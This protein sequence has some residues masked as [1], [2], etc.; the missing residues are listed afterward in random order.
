MAERKNLSGVLASW[1]ADWRGEDYSWRGLEAKTWRGWVVIEGDLVVEFATGRRYGA[2]PDEAP[3]VQAPF[4][5]RRATLQDYWR[6]DPK[7]GKLR[8]VDALLEGGEIVIRQATGSKQDDLAQA[9]TFHKIHLPRLYADQQETAKQSWD[10]DALDKLLI[11]RLRAAAETEFMGEDMLIGADR[12]A[13]FSGAILLSLRGDRLGLKA[14]YRVR[15][16]RAACLRESSPYGATFAPFASFRRALFQENVTFDQA[17][18]GKGVRFQGAIFCGRCSFTDTVFDGDAYF[19]GVS[20][21]NYARFTRTRIGGA[22]QIAGAYCADTADF[23]AA[24]IKGMALFNRATFSATAN[25]AGTHFDDVVRFTNTRF[26]GDARFDRLRCAL[27]AEFASA[28]F[29]GAVSFTFSH[30]AREVDFDNVQCEVDGRS[31]RMNFRTATFSGP[32]H[33]FR[34][35]FAHALQHTANA[36]I[37]AHFEDAVDFTGAGTYWIAALNG[38]TFDR[39]VL[40]D[41]PTEDAANTEFE[42][43]ILA[44]VAPAVR[45]DMAREPQTPAATHRKWR[46]EQIEGGCRALKNAMGRDRDEI[47]EQRYYRFQLIARRKQSGVPWTEKLFSI[48]YG[49][50]A[51]YGASIGA[52]FFW[53]V[54]VVSA[55]ACLYWLAE[56]PGAP[57]LL[58]ADHL[59]RAVTF[60]FSRVLPFGA[61]EDVSKDWLAHYEAVNGRLAALGLRV[62][63][64]VQ[65]VIAVALVFVFGLSI[66]RKFQIG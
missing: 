63:A 6:A 34:A 62:L 61:F 30:F 39:G 40:I 17:S 53:I 7:T 42:R 45:A 27:K 46:L 36:F 1:W 58:G 52:P 54:I 20:F 35:K 18:F 64:S 48:L 51:N 19:N 37:A 3:A 44:S 21:F 65:S 38:V 23:D 4:L 9:D 55:F 57:A 60:S 26:L 8:S 16:E 28:R 25:F 11:P 12:R 29:A 2:A 31:G 59:S 15:L 10:D 41:R 49:W 47:L 33:F 5:G 32:V 43:E 14:P 22:L 56:T 13:Q 24:Q 66:R 50:T